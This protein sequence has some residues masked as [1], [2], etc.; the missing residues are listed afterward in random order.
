MITELDKKVFIGLLEDYGRHCAD[1]AT[2]WSVDDD[3]RGDAAYEDAMIVKRTF[4][5]ILHSRLY[6]ASREQS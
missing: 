6:E 5:G 2:A 4:E 1:A 3:E